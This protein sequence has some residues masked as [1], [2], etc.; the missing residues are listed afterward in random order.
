MK[1]GTSSS[2]ATIVSRFVTSF[3]SF[4]IFDWK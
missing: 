2:E 4:A 3:W 1:V